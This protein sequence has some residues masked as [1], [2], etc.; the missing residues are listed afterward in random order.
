MNRQVSRTI[1]EAVRELLLSLPETVEKLS[2]GSPG[3]KVAGKSFAYLTVN[4]HGDGR[5]ALWLSAPPGVQEQCSESNPS[6]YFVPPYVGPKGWLGVELNKGLSWLEVGE[7]VREAWS[8]N[9]PARLASQRPDIPA[10][11][12]PNIEMTPEDINPWL[13]QHSQE[14]LAGL[15]ERCGRLPETVAEDEAVSATWRA[16][17][18]VFVRGHLATGR[19]KLQFWVGVEQQAMLTED[20]RYTIPIYYGSN[21]WIELDVQDR[22][23]WEEVEGLLESS[24]R[25]FALQRML[26]QLEG[27]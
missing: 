20:P 2:H 24:Y 11:N 10:I 7:R 8:H 26:R 19:L 9:A 12:P 1:P 15:A 27:R 13:G 14:I 3:F 17:K 18:K 6:A 22:V 23:W 21:G 16:G 5:V 4:H 25:H